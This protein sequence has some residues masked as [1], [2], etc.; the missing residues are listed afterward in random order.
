MVRR[1]NP[2][3]IAASSLVNDSEASA[4][5]N[6]SLVI[7]R[8]LLSIA[9]PCVVARVRGARRARIP[10]PWRNIGLPPSR[11]YCSYGPIAAGI[12]QSDRDRV[13]PRLAAAR[14]AG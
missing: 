4:L 2:N 11:G 6:S 7:H 9:D 10:L 13:L 1:P 14:D 12:D 5:Q 3:S 8:M